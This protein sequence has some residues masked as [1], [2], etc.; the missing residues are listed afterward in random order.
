MRTV[1]VSFVVVQVLRVATAL[2]AIVREVRINN[3][4]SKP[5]I[6]HEA[7]GQSVASGQTATFTGGLDMHTDRISLMYGGPYVN[8]NIAVLE[9]N[10]MFKNGIGVKGPRRNLNFIAQWGFMDLPLDV[11]LWADTARSR[12]ACR[13]GRAKCTF[14]AQDCKHI[15]DGSARYEEHGSTGDTYG[16]CRSVHGGSGYYG[17]KAC[18]SGYAVYVNDRCQVFDR[19]T[20]SWKTQGRSVGYSVYGW[21]EGRFSDGL[22]FSSTHTGR[23]DNG[24]AVT[25]ECWEA[26]CIFGSKAE[27]IDNGQTTVGNSGFATDCDEANGLVDVA[28]LEVTACPATSAATARA[29]HSG[30]TIWLKAHTGRYLTVQNDE[31]HAK[32]D[33]RL[34]WEEFVIEKQSSDGTEIQSGDAIYLRAHTGKR[35]TVQGTTVHAEWD[36]QG[37]WQRF[38]LEKVGSHGPIY[39]DDTVYLRAHTGKRL[40]VQGTTVHAEWDHQ[41][42]WQRFTLESDTGLSLLNLSPSSS[43]GRRSLARHLRGGRAAKS[44]GVLAAF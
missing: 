9:L 34:A 15:S 20:E 35:L 6:V 17:P 11:A 14:S 2:D 29:V 33:N 24:A 36:H 23:E 32:W 10:G 22:N 37:S 42:S 4:C 26:P 31:V 16:F 41:G 12:L 7:N 21:T 27:C 44:Q 18:T 5:V 13:D 39:P 43:Q 1:A 25:F 28:V 30:D 38:T 3:Q 40:T 8:D 19:N